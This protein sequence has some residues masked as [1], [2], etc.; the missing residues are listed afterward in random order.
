MIIE[1]LQRVWKNDKTVR[2]TSVTFAVYSMRHSIAVL[3]VECAC[4]L[5]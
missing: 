1:Y 4:Q 3:L 2:E 5:R